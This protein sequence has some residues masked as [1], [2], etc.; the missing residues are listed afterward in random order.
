MKFLYL[1]MLYA[2]YGAIR[3]T[4][5]KHQHHY[6]IDLNQSR[7]CRGKDE[8]VGLDDLVGLF[9]LGVSVKT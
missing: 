2:L 4:L 3:I 5:L 8:M 6:I 7:I 9:S 1:K